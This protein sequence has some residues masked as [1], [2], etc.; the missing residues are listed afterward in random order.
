[1]SVTM[2]CAGLLGLAIGY[3][4]RMDNE[5]NSD[6][7]KN[8]PGHDPAKDRSLMAGLQVVG[9]TVGSPREKLPSF[10]AA[11][12]PGAGVLPSTTRAYYLL[13]GI[14]RV[15]VALNL[16]TI[17]GKDWYGWGSD[18]LVAAQSP[19]GTWEGAYFQGGVD[20]CFALLFLK[21]ANFATD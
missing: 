3:G 18:I 17:A 13:W 9:A 19:R 12:G 14:E 1:T 8:L 11:S 6:K 7:E 16:E 20:T 4:I 5:T 2:T 10:V 15:A 21:K